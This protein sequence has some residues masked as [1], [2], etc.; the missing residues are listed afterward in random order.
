MYLKQIK[1]FG[2]KSFAD[3]VNIDFEL[4]ITGI[5]GPN[6]SGKSN[7]VDAVKWVLGEQS[8]KS[9]RGEGSMTDIIFSGS[10]TRNPASSASVTLIFDNSDSH[11]KIDYREVSIKRTVYRNGDNEYYLNNEKCRLKDILDL[12]MDSGTGRE[13]FNI[14][15]QGDIANILSSKPEDRRI[16]FESAAGVLKYKKRKSDAIKKLEKTHDNIDRV[17]D[18]INEL[19]TQLEPLK[20]QSE[21]AKKYLETKNELESIEVS[22]IASDIEKLNNEY[23]ITKVNID[24]INRDILDM[25]TNSNIEYAR[26]ESEKLEHSKIADKVHKKQQD[27]LNQTAIVERLNSE[28]TILNERKQYVVEDVKLHNNIVNLKEQQLGIENNIDSI[29]KDLKNIKNELNL[30]SISCNDTNTILDEKKQEKEKL[31]SELNSKIKSKTNI[32]YKINILEDTIENNGDLSYSVRSILNNPKL[33]GIHDVIGK[34]FSFE[35]KYTTSLDIVLGASSQFIVVDNETCASNA[36][37]YL[38]SN[39]LGRATFFPMNVI[40]GKIIDEYTYNL[41]KDNKDFIDIASNLVKYDSK[42][43]NIILNQL[44]NIIVT[45]NLAAANKI[46]KVINHKYRVVTL[47]GELLHVGGSITGGINKKNNSVI[48]DKMELDKSIRLNA[49]LVQ[50][51]TTL[52]LKLNNINNYIK[53]IEDKSNKINSKKMSFEQIISIKEDIKLDYQQKLDKISNSLKGTNNILN[54]TLSNEEDSIMKQY[55]D[56]LAVKEDI[57]KELIVLNKKQEELKESIE[58]IEH[59]IKSSNTLFNKSQNDLKDLE[60]KLTRIDVRLDA[61][62]Q[63]LNEDYNMTFDKAKRDYVLILEEGIARKKVNEL[64]SII[65]ELGMVNIAAIE[66]YERVSVRYEFLTNQKGDLYKAENTLLDIIKEMDIVMKESFNDTFKLIQY[67]FKNVFKDLFG[68]GDADLRLTDPLNIL[69]TGI[70][71][72]ATPPGKKL[73]HISLLSGGE[74]ALTAIALLFAILKIRPVP[75]CLLDEVEAPLDEV[76]VENF[77]K[78]LKR[79][80]E[81]TQF[82]V[83]THKKKTMEYADTLYGITMQESGVSKLV[84]VRLNELK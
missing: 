47:D 63:I 52:E 70:E 1:A 12:L 56:S 9:L 39:N 16:I 76:N 77:G 25:T 49:L 60:I 14:I 79:F 15:S 44:G 5:V 8:V 27:L 78:F 81:K 19:E 26:V 32:E 42:Y 68:G 48:L 7:I 53:E 59:D 51:I 20:D 3:R 74:K 24:L 18:I 69:D 2:F 11:L 61:L 34:L 41:I 33:N 73:Q 66:E 72:N 83:I 71:I 62:L 23:C 36:I 22:L 21:K 54:N 43:E 17:N 80:E 58:K 4:G 6:G 28:R 82:I 13:S 40:Q 55:F 31:V 45:T 64:K 37:D 50:D 38:K 29:N 65:K 67:E 30:I 46:S 35:E 75:F 10:K 57:I 84:S